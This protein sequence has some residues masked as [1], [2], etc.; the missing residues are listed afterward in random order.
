MAAWKVFVATVWSVS[1]L[2]VG[3]AA[4]AAELPQVIHKDVTLVVVPPKA[5][6]TYDVSI[7]GADKALTDIRKALDQL[8]RKSPF[9]K[10]AIET[11]R[12]NGDIFLVYDPNFPGR[13]ENMAVPRMAMFF[14]D[15]FQKHGGD[16]EGQAFLAVV[17]RHG[18]KWPTPEL[19][20]L[21]AHEL[22]G[23]AMQQLLGRYKNVRELDLE[24]EAYLYQ[25]MAYQDLGVDKFARDIVIFRK[26]LE[27]HFCSDFKRYMQKRDPA[28]AKLWDV[29]N[30]DV[31]RLL[32]VFDAY[33]KDQRAKAI[34]GTA[35][36]R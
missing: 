4:K 26:N 30:P 17:T 15:Y 24:C 34:S 5:G 22:V 10:T 9:S 6:V 18:I 16:L 32:A 21:I 11:L 25:E 14:P 19:A 1:V 8:Y 27:N 31:P 3:P 33:A 12:K 35:N 36:P 23:H 7:V 29:L 2:G 13:V 20:A 28:S